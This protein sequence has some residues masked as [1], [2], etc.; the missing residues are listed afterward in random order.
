MA[1]EVDICNRALQKL[2]AGSILSLTDNTP[3]AIECN[4][5]YPIVRDAELRKHIWKFAVK[6]VILAPDVATPP[7]GFG[8]Q[9]TLPSDY[10]RTH[11]ETDK[12]LTFQKEGNKIVTND[13]DTLELRYIARITDTT[14]FDALF[15]E[16]LSD[17]IAY[18]LAEPITQSNTKKAEAEDRYDKTIAIAKKVDAIEIIIDNPPQDEW[19]T[20]R[21]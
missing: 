18:D 12:Y 14:L 9:F 17:R 2:G 11:P 8:F 10:L 15:T 13:G 20:A 6:R 3:R 5:A 1:S 21:L 4:L 7:Y 19:I 16:S